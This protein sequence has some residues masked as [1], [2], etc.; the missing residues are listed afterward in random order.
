MNAGIERFV[1]SR[2]TAAM[3]ELNLRFP[4]LKRI[5]LC[6]RYQVSDVVA[7][8]QQDLVWAHVVDGRLVIDPRQSQLTRM[9]AFVM[10]P[11]AEPEASDRL[12]EWN[13]TNSP[14]VGRALASILYSVGDEDNALLVAAK[15]EIENGNTTC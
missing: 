11:D 10:L 2:L 15:R 8:I 7:G 12:K 14:I 13:T 9:Q 4:Y 6:V 1:Q 3:I 5:G